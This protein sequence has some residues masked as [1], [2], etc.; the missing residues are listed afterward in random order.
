VL[1]TLYGIYWHCIYHIRSL[2]HCVTYI[3]YWVPNHEGF[4]SNCTWSHR[5]DILVLLNGNT[6]ESLLQYSWYL[7]WW[8]VDY[9][10]SSWVAWDHWLLLSYGS[11]IYNY[12][13][14]QCLSPLTLGVL[15]PLR[16]GVLDTTLCDLRKVS[17]FLRFPPT[18]NLTA[19]I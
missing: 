19:T 14:N 9:L 6:F 4:R 2:A 16:R 10:Y 7:N 5:Y 3:S 17:G 15:T 1:V 13:G 11:W 12:L 18:I 8:L